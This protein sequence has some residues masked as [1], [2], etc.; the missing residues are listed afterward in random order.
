MV[1]TSTSATARPATFG[2]TIPGL[3][4]LDFTRYAPLDSK[5]SSDLRT[6]TIVDSAL[7]KSP[8][9]LAK[10]LQEQITI[11]PV[12][13]VNF[14]GIHKG[15]NGDEVD[16]DIRLNLLRYFLPRAGEAGL[17]YTKLVSSGTGKAKF[18]LP[19]NATETNGVEQWAQAFCA[20]PAL[21]KRYLLNNGHLPLFPPLTHS[22]F[23]NH[24]KANKLG[25]RILNRSHPWPTSKLELQRSNKHNLPSLSYPYHYQIFSVFWF[26]TTL[27]LCPQRKVRNR[28]LLAIRKP[29][30]WGRL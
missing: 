17:E 28:G 24:P 10:F 13:E 16:F 11:P 29:N 8:Q 15:C 21:D 6:T 19:E 7:C 9:A 25:L 12:P 2:R 26:N 22:Q 5:V 1:S 3:P 27:R 4:S 23:R 14:K 20:D 18:K 30:A